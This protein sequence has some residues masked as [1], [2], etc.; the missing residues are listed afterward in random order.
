MDRRGQPMT[1]SPVLWNMDRTGLPDLDPSRRKT[2]ARRGRDGNGAAVEKDRDPAVIP[3]P[4]GPPACAR[5]LFAR[6]H[7]RGV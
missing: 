2:R 1:R 5:Q 6:H 4:A 3:R 7:A